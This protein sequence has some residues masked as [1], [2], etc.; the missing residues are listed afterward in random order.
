MTCKDCNHYEV[1]LL[2]TEKVKA[3]GIPTYWDVNKDIHNDCF[4]FQDKSK[5]IELPCRVGDTVYIVYN[6]Y[7]LSP[8]EEFSDRIKYK[9]EE[10]TLVS[11][12]M[13]VELVYGFGAFIFHT[14]EEAEAKLKELN[15]NDGKT[16][17]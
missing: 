7:A 5:V 12:P 13:I 14:K 16:N 10:T 1:C 2:Q 15:K 17:S 4:T 6:I 8:F 11:I 9:V 3:L